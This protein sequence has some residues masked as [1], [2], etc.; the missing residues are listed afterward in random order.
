[1]S[2]RFVRP[3]AGDVLRIDERASVQYRGDRALTFR[4][5]SVPEWDTYA[6]WI[7]L[8]GYVLNERG[9]ATERREVFVQLAGLRRLAPPR[10]PGVPARTPATD[11]QAAIRRAN[12]AREAAYDARRSEYDQVVKAGQHTHA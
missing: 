2:G 8:A 11:R 7:W 6:G 3:R 12:P 5:T 1:M 10:R 4:V 9:T